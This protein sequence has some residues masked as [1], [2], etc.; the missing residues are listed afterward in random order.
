[1]DKAMLQELW[2]SFLDLSALEAFGIRA[3]PIFV[4]MLLLTR[5]LVFAIIFVCSLYGGLCLAMQLAG[6]VEVSSEQIKSLLETNEVIALKRKLKT[7]SLRYPLLSKDLVLAQKIQKAL[8][9]KSKCVAD[10]F[11]DDVLSV[12]NYS[13]NNG[14]GKGIGLG[15]M[16]PLCRIRPLKPLTTL[17]MSYPKSKRKWL[18]I[19]SFVLLIKSQSKRLKRLKKGEFG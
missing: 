13:R 6:N 15:M 19:L 3:V 2:F 9:T 7:S 16:L 12:K 8:S 14:K 1:M 18:K 11:I 4:L 10:R 5:K 17:T